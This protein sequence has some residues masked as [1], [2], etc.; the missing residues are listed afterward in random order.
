MPK[1]EPKFHQE[2]MLGGV[3]RSMNDS[4]MIFVSGCVLRGEVIIFL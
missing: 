2:E 1:S 4:L 3:G